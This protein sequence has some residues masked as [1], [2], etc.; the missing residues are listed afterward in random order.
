[1]YDAVYSKRHLQISVEGI[2]FDNIPQP[3]W[4]KVTKNNSEV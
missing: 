1:M 3:L 2:N 4:E